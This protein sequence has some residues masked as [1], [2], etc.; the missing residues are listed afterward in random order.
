MPAAENGEFRNVGVEQVMKSL[1]QIGPCTHTMLV[2]PNLKTIREVYARYFK[3]NSQKGTE[4]IAILPYYETIHS[5]KNNLME[6]PESTQ[7]YNTMIENGTLLIRDSNNLFERDIKSNSFP[8]SHPR[9]NPRIVDFLNRLLSEAK[10]KN[11]N[12]VSVW[13]DT[14]A[15]HNQVGGTELLLDFEKMIPTFYES[16]PLKQFCMY[17]QKDFEMRL[18]KHQETAT[19][20][21]HQKRLMLLGNN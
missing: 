9:A 11:K 10:K 4:M 1:L 15:F 17:H 20:D 2:Y 18:D 7:N 5:V 6:D 8:G 3:A 14:G 16:T 19:F 13:I 12:E 21:Y